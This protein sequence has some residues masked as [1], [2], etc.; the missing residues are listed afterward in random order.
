MSK[1][2]EKK[3]HLVW[4]LPTDKDVM[5]SVLYFGPAPVTDYSGAAMV[6]VPA[7]KAEFLYPEDAPDLQV[8]TD[9]IQTYVA[10]AAED[11]A[12]NL[13]DLW[14]LAIPFDQTPPGPVTN[15]RLV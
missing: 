7:P 9:G 12:G 10:V 14:V 6:K 11:A 8:P 4:E 1:I 5:N 13:S 3:F 2:A 15:L